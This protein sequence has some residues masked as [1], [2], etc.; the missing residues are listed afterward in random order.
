MAFRFSRRKAMLCEIPASP[1]ATEF[2]FREVLNGE[3]LALVRL[4][5]RFWSEH[6]ANNGVLQIKIA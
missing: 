6:P 4:F 2:G 3:T 1:R 5:R